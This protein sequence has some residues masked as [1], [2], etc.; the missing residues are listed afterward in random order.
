MGHNKHIENSSYKETKMVQFTI[1]DTGNKSMLGF[2]RFLCVG[3]GFSGYG[4]SERDAY[5]EWAEA[6]YIGEK[7]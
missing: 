7:D 2:K 5:Q 1:T 4:N 3:D 6:R